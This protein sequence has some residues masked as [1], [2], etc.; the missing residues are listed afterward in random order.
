MISFDVRGI[1]KAQPRPRAARRGRFVHVYN[2]D[3]ADAWKRAVSVTA[4]RHAPAAPLEGPVHL[5]LHFR[6][7]APKR[8]KVTQQPHAHKPDLDNL[9]KAVMD[10]LTQCGFWIDDGQ[11]CRITASKETHAVLSPGCHIQVAAVL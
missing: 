4:N 5:Q 9:A 3:T 7:P 1:P 6:L 8:C 11:V 10:A 2:P